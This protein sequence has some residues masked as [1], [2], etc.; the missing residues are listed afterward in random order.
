[1][2]IDRS[3]QAIVFDLDGTLVDSSRDIAAAVNHAL[4]AHGFP[5]R[6]PK[7][8]A[9]LVG[10]GARWLVAR[11]TELP[12]DDPAVDRVLATYSKYY[13]AHAVDATHPVAATV[14]T[15]TELQGLPLA[16]CTN[17]PRTATDLVLEGLGLACYF[18]IVVAGGDLP[19]LKPDPLP[20]LTIAERL[21]VHARE[22][23]MVG[24]GP[25]DVGCGRAV[26]AFTVGIQGGMTLPQRL[27]DARPDALLDSIGALP[28]QLRAWGW[29]R[30]GPRSAGLVRPLD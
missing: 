1:M 8:L 16:V 25:Q 27:L 11:A 2:Q 14:R 3:P 19:R 7:Q 17:K 6:P 29:V 13:E 15:L 20:L 4:A 18:D 26:G 24:D 21:G 30:G 22:L 10:D 23:V 9:T 28:A 5:T 12:H